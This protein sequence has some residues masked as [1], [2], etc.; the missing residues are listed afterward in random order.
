MRSTRLCIEEI[1]GSEKENKEWT[2]RH[3]CVLFNVKT[4]SHTLDADTSPSSEHRK[5]NNSVKSCAFLSLE[6]NACNANDVNVGRILTSAHARDTRVTRMRNPQLV[7]TV[8]LTCVTHSDT[9]YSCK[10][11]RA[12]QLHT[13]AHYSVTHTCTLLSYTHA[14][15]RT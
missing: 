11:M 15:L 4:T 10:H 5:S 3:S 6:L 2:T 9:T 12:T 8:T 14:H 13:H 7:Y 1:N